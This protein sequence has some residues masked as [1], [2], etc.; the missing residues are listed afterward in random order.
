MDHGDLGLI[1]PSDVMQMSEPDPRF[2]P[3]FDLSKETCTD[4]GIQYHLPWSPAYASVE[5][6]DHCEHVQYTAC[7]LPFLGSSFV[8]P[9]R[10]CHLGCVGRWHTTNS[11]KSHQHRGILLKN[12]KISHQIS[13]IPPRN[14]SHSTALASKIWKAEANLDRPCA[15][16][17]LLEQS[18]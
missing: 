16:V 8:R 15:A 12:G 18:F 11:R 4:Q 13:Q 3:K 10:H 2:I 7:S 17:W 1:A 9:T 14:L 6:Q 5:F